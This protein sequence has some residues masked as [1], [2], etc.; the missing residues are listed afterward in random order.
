MLAPPGSSHSLVSPFTV[1][2][3]SLSFVCM[4]SIPTTGKKRGL[5]VPL[6]GIYIIHYTMHSHIVGKESSL[7]LKNLFSRPT[8]D[9]QRKTERNTG[10]P[11][12]G[13]GALTYRSVCALK[14]NTGVAY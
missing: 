9:Y 13:G 8:S 1:L 6:V 12:R 4:S 10:F 7:L 11:G 3:L 14:S 2:Y 5:R